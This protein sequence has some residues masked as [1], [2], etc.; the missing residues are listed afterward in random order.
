MD[1]KPVPLRYLSV[2]KRATRSA[3]ASD[4]PTDAVSSAEVAGLHYVTDEHAGI[5]RKRA[6]RGF[7]Y[8]DV[9]GK[10]IRD[11]TELR[12]FKSL[13][14][15]PAWTDVWICPRPDG[16]LQAT[17]RDAKGRKQY[18]YHPGWRTVRDATKYHRMIAYGDALPH[19][20][21]RVDRDLA[22]S[23]LPREKV[24]GTVVRLL[25][26]TLIR[27]GNT[28]YACANQSYG[29]TTLRDRHVAFDGSHLRFEFRG[30]SGKHH[31]VELHDRR[32]ARI[33]KRCQD[34]PGYELFQYVD[35]DGQRHQIDSVDVNDYL[36]QIDG[37]D[38]TAK[39]VRT[40]AATVLAARYLWELG[41]SESETQTKQRVAQAIKSVAQ[42]L[43][44]TP[45]I[46]RKSY[47][48]PDVIE[49][50][51]DGSLLAVREAYAARRRDVPPPGL[52]LEEA[53]VLDFLKRRADARSR[54]GGA[55][56]LLKQ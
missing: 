45:A 4:L 5:R 30:K 1:E 48:H 47:V 36:R 27:V 46:C 54:V 17:G 6:G 20:R 8:I 52:H 49:G 10:R 19:M 2:Q 18:R 40:W 55:L 38:F 39:D 14:I 25:E 43:G 41:A 13:A 34:I 15:P 37:L 23:G 22:R 32:L 28:E 56:D 35:T 50:Y 12:R 24:L 42:H 7:Q 53:I 11:P 21:A 31:T 3:Q 44:N 29:L 51:G 16:H 26:I 33:V 9:K